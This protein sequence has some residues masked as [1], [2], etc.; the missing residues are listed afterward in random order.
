LAVVRV[1]A[2][3]GLL[4]EKYG[5]ELPSNLRQALDSDA[6]THYLGRT[7]AEWVG[8]ANLLSK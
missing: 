3:A 6:S 7:E 2:R 5:L 8:L 1:V 4:A